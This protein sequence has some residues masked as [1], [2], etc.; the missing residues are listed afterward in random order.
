[1]QQTQLALIGGGNRGKSL[2]RMLLEGD[3]PVKIAALAEVQQPR[4][5]ETGKLL[6]VPAD[7]QFADYRELLAKCK[8]IDGAIVATDVLTHAQIACDCIDTYDA[9]HEQLTLAYISR[10]AAKIMTNR[11]ISDFLRT[12]I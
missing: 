7:R 5:A 11:E 8:D 4:L 12:A 3:R 10:Y 9:R 1:M 2:S 6:D